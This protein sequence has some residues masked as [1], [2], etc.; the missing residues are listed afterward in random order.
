[1]TS[2]KSRAPGLMSRTPPSLG[3]P[4]TCRRAP[5][6]WAVVAMCVRPSV[7]SGGAGEGSSW[8]LDD[9]VAEEEVCG[10]VDDQAEAPQSRCEV[11]ERNLEI[12]GGGRSAV[13]CG[14]LDGHAGAVGLPGVH[15]R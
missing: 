4:S 6:S 13:P 8:L 11:A 9:D 10:A 2:S 15:D 5:S 1:M 3:R 12:A 14:A 7:S